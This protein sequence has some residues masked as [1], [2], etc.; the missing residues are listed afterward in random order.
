M[1]IDI[2]HHF[3][4]SDLDK[5]S[6]NQVMGWRPAPGTLPWNPEVSL[7]S[8]NASGIDMAILSLPALNIGCVGEENRNVARGRNMY[9]ARIVQ[10]HPRKFGFFASLPLLDD[11]EGVLLEI[12]HAFDVLCADGIAMSS[13]YG[14]GP[15]ATYVGDDRYDPIWAELNRRGA[16]VFLH[17]A[18]V[19]ASTPIQDST[20]CI[21][22]TEVPNETF[23]AAA[24]LVVTGRKRKYPKVR[25]ILAHMGGSTPSLAPRVAVLSNHMGCVLSPTEIME[26]F[27]D[28][29]YDTA[30]SAYNATLAS[31]ETL[32]GPDHILFGT[33]FPAVSTEMADWYTRN[34]EEYY[35]GNQ[36]KLEAILGG[37]ALKLF[38][39]FLSYSAAALRFK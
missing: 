14:S 33:D 4:P 13:S 16:V 22:I 7:R 2:H 34:I 3:F 5:Q 31:L 8:M 25:I 20:L 36:A 9:V 29:Y 11:I 21:P 24:H 28:F 15:A 1:R 10:S 27:K 23:K 37:N 38:P 18:Q 17:G 35:T 30:L 39:R 26:D 32:V 6:S 12:S 19:P